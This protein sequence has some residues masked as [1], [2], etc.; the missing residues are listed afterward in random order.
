MEGKQKNKTAAK[1]LC[2]ERR[3][4]LALTDKLAWR[5]L[6]GT[7]R[8]V[9][10]GKLGE[11]QSLKAVS[12][13]PQLTSSLL[14]VNA[15]EGQVLPKHFQQVVQ[16]QLHAAAARKAVSGRQGPKAQRPQSLLLESTAKASVALPSLLGT[17][18]LS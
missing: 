9:A 10:L 4:G 5:S 2:L 8:M 17:S 7:N 16:V 15:G 18:W 11:A 14:G 6:G 1:L 12:C 3:A 13:L